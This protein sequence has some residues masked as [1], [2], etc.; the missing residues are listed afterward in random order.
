MYGILIVCFLG[1][2]RHDQ[3][4]LTSKFCINKNLVTYNM[5][6]VSF[7]NKKFKLRDKDTLCVA[8]YIKNCQRLLPSNNAYYNIPKLVEYICLCY[9]AQYEYFEKI[10]K[11]IIISSDNTIITKKEDLRN[12]NRTSWNNATYGSLWLPSNDNLIIKWVFKCVKHVI[13]DR[14]SIGIGLVTNKH[15]LK[16]D[17][18]PDAKYSYLDLQ[19]GYLRQNGRTWTYLGCK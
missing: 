13:N 16:T 7:V 17:L 9:Y 4:G 18:D 2:E 12:P 14:Q 19:K 15:H 8:G 10:G 6:T 5:S 3:F 11:D 1:F